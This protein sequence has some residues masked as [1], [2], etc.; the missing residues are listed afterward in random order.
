MKKIFFPLSFLIASFFIGCAS[1]GGITTSEPQS[2]EPTQTAAEEKK[3]DTPE[4]VEENLTEHSP[5][6]KAVQENKTEEN[7]ILQVSSV[8]EKP[9]SKNQQET[10][11]TE[12]IAKIDEQKNPEETIRTE[13]TDLTPVES[14]ELKE[15]ASLSA[16][17]ATAKFNLDTP[18][19]F[20]VYKP[21]KF[22]AMPE[23]K[24]NVLYVNSKNND[25]QFTIRKMVGNLDASEDAGNYKFTNF[26]NNGGI[27]IMAEGNSEDLYN[28]ATWFSGDYS[29][30]VES[31][32]AF[33]KEVIFALVQDVN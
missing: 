22:S 16:A 23:S 21:A 13:N 30:S 18:K 27:N 14:F 4:T 33:P 15:V 10:K 2:A 8:D 26:L 11:S 5:S 28:V 1:T 24:I 25:E 31:N 7:E 32:V 9:D 29:Y 3:S 6:D 17:C 12:E 19:T 20:A